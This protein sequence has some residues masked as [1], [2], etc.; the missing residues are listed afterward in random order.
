MLVVLGCWLVVVDRWWWIGGGG[1]G[2]WWL[3]VV[4]AGDGLYEL[5][6]RGDTLIAEIEASEGYIAVSS[7]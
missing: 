2:W 7:S 3:V 4:P 5:P 6:E 1:D